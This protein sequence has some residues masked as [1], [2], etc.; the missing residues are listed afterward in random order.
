TRDLRIEHIQDELNCCGFRTVRDMAFPFHNSTG[1]YDPKLCVTRYNRDQACLVPLTNETR[2]VLGRLI[3][4]VV[5]A[6]LGG[7]GVSC[8]V[9]L[10]EERVNAG[11]NARTIRYGS[12][13]N[14][15][16]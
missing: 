9:F 12:V 6:V 7:L 1:K 2:A 13:E 4:S 8:F 14:G 10:R 15:T 5:V 11:M 16:N 3:V